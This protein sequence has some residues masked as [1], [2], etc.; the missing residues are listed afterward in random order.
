MRTAL[1][2]ACLSALAA[3]VAAHHSFAVYYFEDETVE[4]EGDVVEFQYRN[5]HSWIF[6]EAKDNFGRPKIYGAEWTGTAG[7]ERQGV[8]SKTIRTGDH[9]RM[10]VSP[11]RNVNEAKVRLK[12][13]E[14]SDGWKWGANPRDTR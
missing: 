5:P 13:I 4:I 8:T 9:V 3:P 14:R 6:V 2:L 7:L 12:R 1:V 10:W 11:N